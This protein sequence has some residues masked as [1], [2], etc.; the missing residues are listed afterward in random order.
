M[1]FKLLLI[2][3]ALFT[4]AACGESGSSAPPEIKEY[5]IKGDPDEFIA[6]AELNGQS[7]F[8]SGT[9]HTLS[10]Y[11]LA[12]MADFSEK[13]T[14]DKYSSQKDLED[15]NSNK[16]RS[17]EAPKNFRLN[18]KPA[19]NG[20]FLASV[21]DLGAQFE[22]SPDNNGQLQLSQVGTAQKMFPVK[23][24]HWSETADK[25][26]ISIL[27]SFHHT[28][29]GKGIAAVYFRS[30]SVKK[31]VPMYN[32]VY[33]YLAGPGVGMQWNQDKTL[34]IETCGANVNQAWA[35]SAVR[36][37]S[38]ALGDRLK[39]K[40]AK[41]TKYAPFS[42]LNQ[43]CIY[44]LNVYDKSP[45]NANLGTTVSPT[46]SNT[47]EIVDGDVIIFNAAFKTLEK[48]YK[49][50]G[51]DDLSVTSAVVK[52]EGITYTHEVGH[53]LG[54][55]HKFDGTQSIMSYAFD[56]MVLTNYDVQAIQTLYPRDKYSATSVAEKT[57]NR[58]K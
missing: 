26:M 36:Q 46:N 33:E 37:W 50:A 27:F 9:L 10:N 49:D 1:V 54:L 20:K 57:K 2:S 3:M 52:N 28:E 12:A 55:H 39:I 22:F 5:V 43:R 7:P 13:G 17:T 44:A 38:T 15:K 24:L 42:D 34:Q 6:G 19:A 47:G 35:Q 40:F 14:P 8:N 18:I 53:L 23:T 29:F 21:E 51:L 31:N 16:D 41:A 25:G 11:A 56:T 4:L 45:G 48:K 58:K 32:K 30:E